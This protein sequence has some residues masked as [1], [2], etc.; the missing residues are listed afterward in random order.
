MTWER[1]GYI[2]RRASVDR[3]ENETVSVCLS[4][5]ENDKACEL[6]GKSIPSNSLPRK[7]L[8]RISSIENDQEAQKAL[9]IYRELSFSKKLEE[10]MRFKRVVAYLSLVI[11]IFYVVAGI[12]QFKVAPLFLEAF[13]VFDIKTP[14]YLTLYQDYGGYFV[15]TVSVIMIY[16]LLIGA[17]LRKLFN[18]DLG[19]E[20]SWLLR[21]FVF[22]SIR[23]SYLKVINIIQ[24]PIAAGNR[25]PIEKKIRLIVNHLN[26]I[27]ESKLDISREM[28]ELIEIEMQVLL[29]S[30]EKQMKYISIIT[31]LIVISMVFL[32]L[33]SAYSPIFIL[34]E[35]V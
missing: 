25:E 14:K 3:Q 30:C 27:K 21:L 13:E 33:F 32:F 11:F 22:P 7:I 6:Y 31:S 4:R 16:S 35:T 2:C 28:H 18:F 20:N 10:P 5:I 29:E 26:N 19:R 12:Y 34:G 24:F 8:N 23:T 17:H 1:F 15:L 9:D